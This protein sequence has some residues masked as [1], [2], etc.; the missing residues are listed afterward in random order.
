MMSVLSAI[1][2]WDKKVECFLQHVPENVTHSKQYQRSLVDIILGRLKSLLNYNND[3]GIGALKSQIILLRTKDTHGVTIE[4]NYSLQK[5]S[6]QPI[7]VHSLE[8]NH[9]TILDNKDCANIINRVLVGKT[10]KL[11]GK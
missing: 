1:D 11:V 3:D 5:Y 7:V 6:E 9:V 4:E 2:S 10:K 8:G